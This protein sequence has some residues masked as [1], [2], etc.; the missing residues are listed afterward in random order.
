M[1]TFSFKKNSLKEKEIRPDLFFFFPG[2]FLEALF[3]MVFSAVDW[4]R[5]RFI[6]GRDGCLRRKSTIN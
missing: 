5:F 6:I 1:C 3:F 2:L 4:I